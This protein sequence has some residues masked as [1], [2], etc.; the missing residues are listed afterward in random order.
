MQRWINS[1]IFYKLSSFS[2]LASQYRNLYT[3]GSKQTDSMLSLFFALSIVVWNFLFL[4]FPSSS[5]MSSRLTLVYNIDLL[6][7]RTLVATILNMFAIII[8][9]NKTN[10][11][12]RK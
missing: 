11:Y 2:A 10:K 12:S 1:A 7:F 8:K 4:L 6:F 9:I 3:I 5:P